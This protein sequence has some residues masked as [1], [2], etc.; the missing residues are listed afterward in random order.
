MSPAIGMM[1]QEIRTKSAFILVPGAKGGVHL[2]RS[3]RG[4]T[5]RAWTERLN[6]TLSDCLQGYDKREFIRLKRQYANITEL[7]TNVTILL[8]VGNDMFSI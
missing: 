8:N 6:M 2:T 4:M 7:H 5:G 1:D 3:R